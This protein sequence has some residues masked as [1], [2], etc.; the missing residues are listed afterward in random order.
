[1]KLVLR[2]LL[3]R[4]IAVIIQNHFTLFMEYGK[5]FALSKDVAVGAHPKRHTFTVFLLRMF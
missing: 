4:M 1:M 2:N 5:L 3:T